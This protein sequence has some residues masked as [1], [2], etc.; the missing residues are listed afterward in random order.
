MT[1]RLIYDRDVD[2]LSLETGQK[3][4]TSSSVLGLEE[5]VVDL[6]TED[7]HDV[8]GL[9][10]MGAQAYLPLGTRGYDAGSDTLT[11]GVAIG[12]PDLITENGDLVAY[13]QPD[14][15]EPE[16]FMHPIGVA[17][18]NASRHLSPMLIEPANRTAKP[19]SV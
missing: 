18:R 6:A 4:A 13:W 12:D 14:K 2:V 15:V 7:G 19:S 11:L 16:G 10:I 5:V 17:V 8:T 3:G 9:M 1:L